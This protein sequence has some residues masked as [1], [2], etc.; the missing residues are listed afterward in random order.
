M[1]K[2]MNLSHV[3]LLRNRSYNNINATNTASYTKYSS[4]SEL[5]HYNAFKNKYIHG[6]KC[7]TYLC[8]KIESIENIEL[9]KFMNNIFNCEMTNMPKKK[10]NEDCEC[11]SVCMAKISETQT[12]VD[13]SK[14]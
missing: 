6:D 2:M 5:K 8:K 14:Q 9:Y 1:F 10:G 4:F 3:F 13:N 11:E 7:S 12:I